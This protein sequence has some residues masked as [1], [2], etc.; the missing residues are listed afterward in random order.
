LGFGR[1]VKTRG[2]G[3]DREGHLQRPGPE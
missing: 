1:L 3:A 2:A